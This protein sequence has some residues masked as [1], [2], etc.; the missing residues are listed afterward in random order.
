MQLETR[1]M[2]A[3]LSFSFHLRNS[4]FGWMIFSILT[5]TEMYVRLYAGKISTAHGL[6]QLS[7]IYLHCIVLLLCLSPRT[8]RLLM[9]RARKQRNLTGNYDHYVAERW[10]RHQFVCSGRESL[11]LYMGARLPAR[12]STAQQVS[13]SCIIRAVRV[14]RHLL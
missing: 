8:I 4:P 3:I 1:A 7:Q 13:A 2:D 14:A 9:K 11:C 12:V 5:A 6:A 10:R